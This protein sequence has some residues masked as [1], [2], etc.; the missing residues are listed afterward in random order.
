MSRGLAAQAGA[1]QRASGMGNV[2]G[3]LVVVRAQVRMS[4]ARVHPLCGLLP[5]H[6]PI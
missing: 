6:Q 5:A 3:V 2:R 1:S 4:D